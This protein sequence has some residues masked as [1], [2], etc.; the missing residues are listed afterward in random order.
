MKYHFLHLLACSAKRSMLLKPQKP[1]SKKTLAK[2]MSC[3][4][5]GRGS[6]PKAFYTANSGHSKLKATKSKL[7][8]K[9]P[10]NE[11]RSQIKGPRNSS[12]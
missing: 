1:Q 4:A 8:K 10:K 3:E 12:T 6:S 2:V 7:L 5:I 11:L 9:A